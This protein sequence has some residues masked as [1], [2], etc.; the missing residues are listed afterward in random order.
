[1]FEINISLVFLIHLLVCLIYFGVNAKLNSLSISIIKFTIVF[2]LPVLGFIFLIIFAFSKKFIKKSDNCVK[3][4][5]KFTHKKNF[6]YYEDSIDFEKEINTI[7]LQD[8]LQFDDS[9][10]KRA[11]LIY[12]L[13]KNFDGHIA[14]LKK[15]LKSGDSETSH[16]AAAALMEIKNQFENKLALDRENYLKNK[17]DAH[18]LEIYANTIKAYLKSNVSDNIDYYDFLS[19]YSNLLEELIDKGIIK[20]EYFEDKISADLFFAEYDKALRYCRHY[21]KTYPQN[22]RPLIYYLKYCFLKKDYKSFQNFLKSINILNLESA[23]Q[24]DDIKKFWEGGR[25]CF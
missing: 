12:V 23:E 15:A 7:P 18:A 16:Y 1:M 25:I 2:F 6:I 17:E 10:A 19:T 3:E 13:K 4:F 8:S 9:K 24:L 11:Y 22:E 20:E 21:R 5:L 14:G